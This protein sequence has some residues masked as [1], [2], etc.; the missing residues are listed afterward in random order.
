MRSGEM[1]SP[2]QL[3]FAE[4]RFFAYLAEED[5]LTDFSLINTN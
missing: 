2:E 1:A 5:G 3:A 4:Q